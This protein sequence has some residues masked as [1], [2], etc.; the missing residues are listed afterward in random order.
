MYYGLKPGLSERT[1]AGNEDVEDVSAIHQKAADV[2]VQLG[3][4]E[5]GNWL[6]RP[7]EKGH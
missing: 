7:P 6:L 3:K 4:G 2:E 1:G 5:D